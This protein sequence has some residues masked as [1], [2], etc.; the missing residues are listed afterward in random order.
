MKK[1]KDEYQR[2][3]VQAIIN[4]PFNSLVIAATG[5]GKSKIAIDFCKLFDKKAKI[6]LV[7]PTEELRDE[8]WKAEFKTW[9]QLEF[10]EDNIERC[11]YASLNKLKNKIYDLVILDEI[12]HITANNFEFFNQNKVNKILALTATEPAEF[13]KKDLLKKLKL[14]TVTNISIDE[15]VENE[16]ISPF[17]IIIV[18]CYLDD[19]L[20]YLPFGSKKNQYFLTEQIAYNKLT[21]DLEYAT[22]SMNFRRKEQLTFQRM[23][24]I[25]NS[26]EKTNNAKWTLDN[27]ITE[28]ERTLIFCGSI[29]QAELLHPNTY[30]SK[31]NDKNLIRFKNEEINKLSCVD[32][33]N[34]GHN[35]PNLDSAIITQVKSKE[36]HLIQRIG[37]I[38]RYRLNHLGKIYIFVVKDTVDEGWL[39][40]AIANIS[41]PIQRMDFQTFR[42]NF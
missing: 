29:K 15:A 38:V 34:E 4:N 2:E 1:T 19:K 35:F 26:L 27:L 16:L 23:R 6:L 7:V 37:R 22:L 40:T 24:L 31:T 17:E 39:H 32:A 5:V 30:H 33:L 25:Y 3:S 42:N 36:R 18:D 13:A 8:N 9:N 41:A 12:Q 21:K 20:K 10:Y 14:V 11:C 28:Q